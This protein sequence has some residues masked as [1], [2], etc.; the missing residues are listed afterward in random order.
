MPAQPART[1]AYS[2]SCP[3]T[4]SGPAFIFSFFSGLLFG[5]S[6]PFFFE[7]LFLPLALLPDRSVSGNREQEGGGYPKQPQPD[8]TSLMSPQESSLAWRLTIPVTSPCLS[9]P[10][11]ELGELGLW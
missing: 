9:A 3:R 2:P 10:G 7:S 4:E 6:R 8:P 11:S 1:A 5:P